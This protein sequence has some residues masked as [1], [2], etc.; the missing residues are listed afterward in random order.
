MVPLLGPK[1]ELGVAKVLRYSRYDPVNQ[2]LPVAPT[3]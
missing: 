1:D 3:P 2:G